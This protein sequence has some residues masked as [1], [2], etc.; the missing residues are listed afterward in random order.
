VLATLGRLDKAVYVE[1]ASQK[2]E[3]VAMFTEIDT[4]TVPYFAM[5]LVRRDHP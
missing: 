1:R 2:R 5:I 3:R 4:E